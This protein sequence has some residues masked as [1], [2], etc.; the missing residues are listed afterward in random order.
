MTKFMR[1]GI[2]G[3]RIS[4]TPAQIFSENR[5]LPT[6]RQKSLTPIEDRFT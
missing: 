1:V 5:K 4:N 6:G 2:N 3:C